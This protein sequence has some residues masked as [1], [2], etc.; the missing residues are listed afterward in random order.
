[1]IFSVTYYS[2]QNVL[3]YFIIDVYVYQVKI[4]MLYNVQTTN[5]TIVGEIWVVK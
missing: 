2:E 4:W 5:S 1:M 3:I